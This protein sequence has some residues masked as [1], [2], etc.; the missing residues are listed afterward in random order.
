MMIAGRPLQVVRRLPRTTPPF[1]DEVVLS[2]LSRLGQ[3]NSFPDGLLMS[4]WITENDRQTALISTLSG[5]RIPVLQCALPE[6]RLKSPQMMG[7]SW[8]THAPCYRC[9]A[10]RAPGQSVNAWHRRRVRL[11][12]IHWVWMGNSR[13]PLLTGRRPDIHAAYRRHRRLEARFG[14][15]ATETA[16]TAASNIVT[17]WAEMNVLVLPSSEDL[18]AAPAT[19]TASPREK[20]ATRASAHQ[21]PATVALTALLADPAWTEQ[22]LAARTWDQL[23]PTFAHLV[24]VSYNPE[25]MSD[26]LHRWRRDAR[27]QQYFSVP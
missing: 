15:Q 2:Y 24:S 13:Y 17:K 18:P 16:F 21:Y 12:P 1:P 6:L 26:P 25:G 4:L 20:W 22:A 27:D 23:R 9:A 3:I 10:R 11:C 7:P 8:Y 5:Y 19:G 14:R